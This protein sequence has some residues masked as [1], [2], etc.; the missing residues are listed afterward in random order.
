MTLPL[1]GAPQL[2]THAANPLRASSNASP[3]TFLFNF[4]YYEEQI[5]EE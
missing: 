3:F 2:A 1:V 5:K 4:F